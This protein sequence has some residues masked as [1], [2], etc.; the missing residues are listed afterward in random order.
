[1]KEINGTILKQ[2]TAEFK[3]QEEGVDAKE[4]WEQVRTFQGRGVSE[5]V[6]L[7]LT[8]ERPY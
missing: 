2:N 6:K 8:S 4:L 5:S 1:M 7:L 3:Q